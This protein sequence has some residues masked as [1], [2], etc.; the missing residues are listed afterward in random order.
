MSKAARQPCKSQ[1]CR[2]TCDKCLQFFNCKSTF[3]KEKICIAN[4]SRLHNPPLSSPPPKLPDAIRV[5]IKWIFMEDHP[6]NTVSKAWICF[7]LQILTFID[8]NCKMIANL[9]EC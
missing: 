7:Y 8:N 1:R 2:S 3:R 6:L 4:A 9:K 5:W